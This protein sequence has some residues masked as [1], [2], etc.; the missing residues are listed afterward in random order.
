MPLSLSAV[1][2]VVA[3]VL[4]AASTAR[5]CRK[6]LQGDLFSGDGHISGGVVP[7]DVESVFEC[8]A[9]SAWCLGARPCVD[10]VAGWAGFDV[11]RF[12]GESVFDCS[13]IDLAVGDAVVD[14]DAADSVACEYEA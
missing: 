5:V 12:G 6:P 4:L 10:A 14:I 3:L 8:P 9:V 2:L 13:A 7:F 11:E 1:D